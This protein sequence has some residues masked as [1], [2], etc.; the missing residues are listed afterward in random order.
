MSTEMLEHIRDGSKSHWILHRR[1]ARYKISDKIKQRQ[2]EWKV[3]LLSMQNMG[4]GLHTVFK[5]VLNDISKLLPILGESG[6]EVSYFVPDPR[7]FSEVTR[8][9]DDINKPWLQETLKDI[10]NMINNK[11]VLFQGPEKG[12]PVTPCMDAYKAKI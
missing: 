3:E 8:L 6:S 9:S 1:E 10:K 7:K 12:E 5:Y 11:N 4:K 2:K